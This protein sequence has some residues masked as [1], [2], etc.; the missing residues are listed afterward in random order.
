MV[1][2]APVSST[3]VWLTRHHR[4]ALRAVNG[5][6]GLAQPAKTSRLLASIQGQV[7]HENVFRLCISDLL[8]R[9]HHFDARGGLAASFANTS[10]MPWSTICLTYPHQ[11]TM[12]GSPA[13]PSTQ[14]PGATTRFARNALASAVQN[15]LLRSH[16][17]RVLATIGLRRIT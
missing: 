14:P 2:P 16:V 5:H 3:S 10:R 6:L 11:H 15:P 17:E 13:K 7:H 4:R 9:A 12:H 8:S 1:L